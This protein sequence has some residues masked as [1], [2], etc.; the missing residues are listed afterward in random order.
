L[1]ARIADVAALKLEYEVATVIESGTYN[2]APEIW[3]TRTGG[4][5]AAEEIS[6]ELM[7]WMDYE[8]LKPA[9]TLQE[10]VQLDGR[11][12]EVFYEPIMGDAIKWTYVAFRAVTRE[13]THG[14]LHLW[15]FLLY[16]VN[17]GYVDG[18]HFV[19]SLEFG[20]EIGSGRGQTIL[21]RLVV[22]SGA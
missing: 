19:S 5:P 16:A 22:S 12:F 15:P 9:G 7:F 6:A 20:N 2:L 8:G 3:I 21:N 13:P 10:T 18:G 17:K 11:P 14:R 4:S 1:P